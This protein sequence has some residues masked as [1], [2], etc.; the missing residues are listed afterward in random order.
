MLV[1]DVYGPDFE[2]DLALGLKEVRNNGN[3]FY[4]HSCRGAMMV[5]EDVCRYAVLLPH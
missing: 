5:A 2:H 1:N 3:V 4:S